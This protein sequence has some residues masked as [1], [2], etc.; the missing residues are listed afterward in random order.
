[1]ASCNLVECELEQT[2]DELNCNPS[3]EHGS[4]S[5]KDAE[6]DDD[7]ATE[8]ETDNEVEPLPSKMA[9]EAGVW[10]YK[11]K[12]Q[13]DG[14]NS[15]QLFSR[16]LLTHIVFVAK[17]KGALDAFCTFCDSDYDY[18]DSQV[19]SCEVVK[20][21]ENHYSNVAA[22]YESLTSYECQA[23]LKRFYSLY[24]PLKDAF[25]HHSNS[26]CVFA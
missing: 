8:S 12:F 26:P 10:C 24:M 16:F 5:D 1:M 2:E 9:V 23:R 4:E 6:P 11:T 21:R 22:V 20:P 17:H 15:G 25:L 14:R 13:M 7:K 19:R 3:F 18:R